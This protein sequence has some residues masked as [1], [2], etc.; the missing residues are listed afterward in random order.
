MLSKELKTLLCSLSGLIFLLIFLIITGSL[1]WIVP[2]EYNIPENGYASMSQFFVLAPFLLMFLIPALA[3]R[4][5]AE[6]KRSHTLSLLLTRPVSLPK[7]VF[8]KLLAVWITV[9][10][11][12]IPTLIYVVWIY[13]MGNPVGNIDLGAVIASYTGLLFLVL[14]FSCLSIFTSSA[15]SN[16]TVALILGL[17]LIGCLFWGFNLLSGLFSSGE[18]QISV[19]KLGLLFHYQSVQRGLIDSRDMIYMLAVSCFFFLLTC[20]VIGLNF[21]SRFSITGIAVFLLIC[22]A[23]ILFQF[24][25]DWTKD[26]R[27]TISDVTKEILH[28]VKSDIVIDFYLDGKLNSGFVQLKKATLDMI[29]DFNRA[30]S[31]KITVQTIN[32]YQVTDKNF[33][34][35]LN[36]NGIKGIAVNEKDPEGRI[37]QHVLFP[38]MKIKYDHSEIAVPLLVNQQGRSGEEN[39]NTS[40]EIL[41]YQLTHAIQTLTRKNVQKIV[42]L[43]GHGELDEQSLADL[44]D[45]L[46]NS[47]QIDRGTMTNDIKQLND[48]QLVIIAG[49]QLPYS[50]QE[51]YILDQYLMQGGKILWIINGVQLQ[52]AEAL[53]IEGKTVSRVNDVNLSDLLFTYGVR[54]NP[55]LIQDVQCMEVPVNVSS[56]STAPEYKLKPWNFAPLLIPNQ[57]QPI[58]KGLTLIKSEFA[59][60][61]SFPGKT[62]LEMQKQI[63]LMSSPG[64]HLVPVPEIISLQEI[65][66][67]PDPAYYN[68]S[69][70]PVAALLD[71][72][73]NSGFRNRLTPDS[74]KTNGQ[75]FYSRSKPT[76]MIVI[77]S[78][79]I[80][81][82]ENNPN[83]QQG[84]WPIGY[85][86]Y[87]Q[88]QF[89]NRDFI[90]NA[91]NFLTDDSGLM[92][93]R[94]K[95]LTL[96]LLDRQ[97]TV[98]N[99]IT[100]IGWNIIFPPVFIIISFLLFSWTRKRKYKSWR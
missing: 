11:A 40:I 61:L 34:T 36:E 70:L 82:N 73:F 88:I 55:V 17:L 27:Y 62:D 29:D 19:R 94:N 77:A 95:L 49:P 44:S 1:L 13:K 83:A 48:Y 33:I 97:K 89:G 85:D 78:E 28:Q 41:E 66:R 16:Q 14:C 4:T 30:T 6:E 3:M 47:Y 99:K 92:N 31:G 69:Y 74:V 7:I 24:R 96:R 80:I 8:L 57:N 51:K 25:M 63:L 37:S 71:G 42:F 64:T 50:E 84:Y 72:V 20:Y 56:E 81:R 52:S 43:E 39:L 53:A 100:L 67:K 79:E 10:I 65:D 68:Q 86:P 5:F 45:I 98:E 32:P 21:R 59:S 35:Q 76:Q 46:E 23:G 2:G 91:V 12:L 38:W 15:T 22:I 93:I 87:S 75:P 58:T 18:T 9:I 26:K 60:T 54:I 90:L